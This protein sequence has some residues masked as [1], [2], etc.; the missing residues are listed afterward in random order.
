MIE[1]TETSG[2]LS[3]KGEIEGVTLLF[4]LYPLK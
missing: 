3:A 2:V 1:G 4:L